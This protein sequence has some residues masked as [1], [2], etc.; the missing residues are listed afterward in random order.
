MHPIRQF[1]SLSLVMLL[2]VLA[3]GC[4]NKL[5]KPTNADGSFN[6]TVAVAEAKITYTNAANDAATYAETCHAT[7]PAPIGCNERLI[8][9]LKT[10][11]VTTLEAINA[12]EQAV[13]TLAPGSTG[14]DTALNRMNAALIFLQSLLHTAKHPNASQ[15]W[16]TPHAQGAFA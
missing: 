7:T 4:V 12:A 6:P 2:A 3:S 9:Q 13:R 1:V 10:Q 16:I 5:P 14:I 15:G 8:A 11:S